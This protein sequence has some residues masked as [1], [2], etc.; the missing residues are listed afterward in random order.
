MCADALQFAGR[1]TR[2]R[3]IGVHMCSPFLML[4]RLVKDN[5]N[6]ALVYD[7]CNPPK[8]R[9]KLTIEAVDQ[10]IIVRNE[11]KLYYN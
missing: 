4:I 6:Q 7:V 8:I 3:W 11:R 2:R 5:R 9:T 10:G 1:K